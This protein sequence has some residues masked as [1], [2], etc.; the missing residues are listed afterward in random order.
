M[1]GE[2][3]QMSRETVI[4]ARLNSAAIHLLRRIRRQDPLSGVSAAR[5]SALSVI[6]YSGPLTMGALAAA[7][8]VRLP[9]ISRLVTALVYDGLVRREGDARDARVVKVRATD[10]GVR[11]L[12]EARQR[13]VQDLARQLACL[14]PQELD[15]LDQAAAI[16]E[17]V[18]AMEP[19]D[20]G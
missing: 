13:R 10:E 5:L 4:A 11:I 17:R 19:P 7:E 8:Q 15:S 20:P 12:E 2:R 16:I 18:I 6:V 14:S 1:Q 3:E 9:T